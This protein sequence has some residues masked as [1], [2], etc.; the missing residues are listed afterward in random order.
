MDKKLMI[1]PFNKQ[2]SVIARY[3]RL[4]SGYVLASAVSP[5]SYG[6]EGKDISFM[7]GGELVG[8]TI[9]C[10]F[11]EGLSQCDS[12]LFCTSTFRMELNYYEE[13]IYEAASRDKEIL[14][15]KELAE[16]FI[17]DQR[18]IPSG[19]KILGAHSVG[20]KIS[21][22][23]TKHIREISVP[24]MTIFQIGDFC[25]GLD[26]LLLMV[27]KFEKEGYQVTK[28]SSSSLAKLFGI[29]MLPDYIYDS[30]ISYEDK[31]VSFNHFLISL[32]ENEQCDILLL[33][34]DEAILPY[35]DRHTNH[36]GV[37]PSII[38]KAVLA[39]VSILNIYYDI[40]DKRY[41][42]HLRA[43]CRY[44]LNAVVDYINIANTSMAFKEFEPLEPIYYLSVD[45][46]EVLHAIASDYSD[47]DCMFFHTYDSDSVNNTYKAIVDK[48]SKNKDII[49]IW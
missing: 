24:V 47:Y 15:T 14:I 17:S 23:K 42:D 37:I 33:E 18:I 4:L 11:E 7:D 32:T 35:S 2:I 16:Y 10:S 25:H 5:K 21:Y 3:S 29:H 12:I 43:Y 41:L 44:A 34:I 49:R 36:F 26:S 20:E 45:K 13:K 40:Y 19:I 22:T 9:T 8:L 6:C 27:E 28:V 31:I 39:D 48:L 1:Y 38:A 30:H 46:K